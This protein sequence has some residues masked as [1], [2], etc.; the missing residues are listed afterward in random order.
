MEDFEGRLGARNS[1]H[2]E[3]DHDQDRYQTEDGTQ[4]DHG[5]LRPP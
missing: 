2:G 4:A 5:D 3:G 1:G